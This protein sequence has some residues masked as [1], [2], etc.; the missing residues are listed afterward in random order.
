MENDASND[1]RKRYARIFALVGLAVF[2]VWGY[3]LWKQA[4]PQE[5]EI[6]YSYKGMIDADQVKRTVAWVRDQDRLVSRVTFYHP[7]PMPSEGKGSF[8]TQKLRLEEGSYQLQVVLH[9]KGK[10][11]V[12][13]QELNIHKEGAYYIYLKG[14]QEGKTP[15]DK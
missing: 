13:K 10:K 1:K 5:V 12:L 11:R 4:F 3:S 15:V 7:R 9:Y 8:R 14:A 6:R 2:V